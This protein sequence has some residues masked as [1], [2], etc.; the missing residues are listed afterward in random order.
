MEQGINSL[1]KGKEKW[2]EV[3]M[4]NAELDH[5]YF[6]VYIIQCNQGYLCRNSNVDPERNESDKLS[7]DMVN[8]H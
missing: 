3:H 8:T 6:L 1:D 5:V 4:K 2:R 7:G